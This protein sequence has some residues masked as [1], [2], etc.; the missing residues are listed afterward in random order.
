MVSHWGFKFSFSGERANVPIDL[1]YN[2]FNDGSVGI[3]LVVFFFNGKIH[4]ENIY[5][6]PSVE[7]ILYL[8]L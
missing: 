2:R 3:Y 7:D 6:P 5:L 1:S 8:F 4:L